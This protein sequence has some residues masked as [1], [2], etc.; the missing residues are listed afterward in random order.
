MEFHKSKGQHILKNPQVGPPWCQI[1]A[2]RFS[3]CAFLCSKP[4]CR[5]ACI[6]KRQTPASLGM[7]KQQSLG[8]PLAHTGIQVFTPACSCNH[9]FHL[10]LRILNILYNSFP[11]WSNAC[12][13]AGDAGSPTQAVLASRLQTLH[14]AHTV[15]ILRCCP[16]FHALAG[17]AGH[18]G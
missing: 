4:L 6:C 5:T 17:G 16:T 12:A 11:C 14:D 1:L 7:D 18:C 3:L 15:L 9:T 8:E 10:I 13:C 2:A